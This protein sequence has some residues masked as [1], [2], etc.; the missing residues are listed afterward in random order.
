LGVTDREVLLGYGGRHYR[1]SRL[2][3]ERA[4]EPSD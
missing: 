4:D 1:Y 2:G 3:L